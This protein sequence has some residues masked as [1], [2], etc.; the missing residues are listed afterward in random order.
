MFLDICPAPSSSLLLRRAS[1]ASGWGEQM[2]IA[3]DWYLLLEMALRRPCSAAFSLVPRW[4]KRVDG[5]NVY[6]GRP[7]AE[8]VRKLYLHDYRFFARDF[9]PHLTRGERLTLARR[10]LKYRLRLF[11]HETAR[12]DLASRAKIPLIVAHLRGLMRPPVDHAE[13]AGGGFA[14]DEQG[15]GTPSL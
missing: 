2:R 8:M 3:D 14:G 15:G 7:F 10:A 11:L 12:T 13:G 1:I 4:R 6:D 9:R 5:L